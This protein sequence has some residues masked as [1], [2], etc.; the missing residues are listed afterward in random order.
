MNSVVVVVV[1]VF[2]QHG[3]RVPRC[4]ERRHRGVLPGRASG[5]LARR[6]PRHRPAGGADRR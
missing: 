3:R 6:D 4:G 1:V 5:H 2:L